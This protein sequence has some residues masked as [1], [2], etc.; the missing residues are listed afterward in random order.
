MP[1]T[2]AL[3]TARLLLRPIAL[4]DAEQIQLAFPQWEI[5]RHLGA[6]VPW[7]Y[8]PDGALSYLRD[9]LLPAVERGEVWSWTVRLKSAPERIIGGIDL[10][11]KEGDHRGFW[12]IPELR[13]RGLM[14]E[15]A[16]AATEFWFGVLKFPMLRTSKAAANVASRRVSEKQGMRM[17]GKDERDYICGRLPSETWEITADEWRALK[18]KG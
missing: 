4:V 15:A 18:R 2:P 13:G 11:R 5:V 3:E 17:V 1:P 9:I 10:R 16:D 6:T 7:P 14:T 8:P 12:L